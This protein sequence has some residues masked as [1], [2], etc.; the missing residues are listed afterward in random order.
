MNDIALSKYG[1]NFLQIE[2]KGTCNMNCLF[3]PYEFKEKKSY[4][5]QKEKVGKIIR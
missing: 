4:S 3:C 2:T 1:Y 5:L